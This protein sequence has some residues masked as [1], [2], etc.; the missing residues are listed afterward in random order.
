MIQDFHLLLCMEPVLSGL[1][2]GESCADS[3]RKLGYGFLGS[4]MIVSS[5]QNAG[6]DI[7]FD[8]MLSHIAQILLG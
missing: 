2:Y 5:I 6:G 1:H 3:I 4:Q 8:R 7:P